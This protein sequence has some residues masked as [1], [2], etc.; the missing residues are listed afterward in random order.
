MAGPYAL[1]P[2]HVRC[3]LVTSGGLLHTSL[4]PLA[5][6]LYLSIASWVAAARRAAGS[7]EKAGMPW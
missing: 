1:L 3:P 6:G 4:T 2:R 7:D 5:G